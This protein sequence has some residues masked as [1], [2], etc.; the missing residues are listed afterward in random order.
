MEEKLMEKGPTLAE[1][2]TILAK[3]AISAI[4]DTDDIKFVRF[5]YED[6]PNPKQQNFTKMQ[7]Q[8]IER[9][10]KWGRLN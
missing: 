2:R 4:R 6:W 8:I 5:Y 1:A 7:T 10:E 9:L 3:A